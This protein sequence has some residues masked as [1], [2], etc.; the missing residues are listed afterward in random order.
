MLNHFRS[1][2]RRG[3]GLITEEGLFDGGGYLVTH[4][5]LDNSLQNRTKCTMENKYFVVFHKTRYNY[6]I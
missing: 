5:I 4:K 1:Y 2:G 6:I 3:G